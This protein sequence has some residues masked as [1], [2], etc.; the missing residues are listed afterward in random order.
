MFSAA[1]ANRRKNEG[2]YED[3]CEVYGE[4]I[5]LFPDDSTFYKERGNILFLLGHF[6]EALGAIDEAIYLQPENA[7][8]YVSKGRVLARQKKFIEALFDYQRAV[9]LGTSDFPGS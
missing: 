5:R 2:R 9:T 4:L 7:Q 1:I 3:A 8:L 6:E